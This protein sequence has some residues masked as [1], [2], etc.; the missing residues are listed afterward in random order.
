LPRNISIYFPLIKGFANNVA[1]TILIYWLSKVDVAVAPSIFAKQ[2]YN[3]L[4]VKTKIHIISNGV[5]LSIFS[6]N[7]ENAQIF[8]KRY[9]S[10]VDENASKALFVGRIMPDKDIELFIRA[11]QN[12][13]VVP[14]LVGSSWPKYIHKLKEIDQGKSVFTGQIPLSHLRGAY[15]ACDMFV[16][17]CTTELQSLSVLEALASELPV[18][19]ADSGSLPEL[20]TNQINGFLFSL[21][22]PNDLKEKINKLIL[23][24]ELGKKM[25]VMGR[26]I[27]KK[28]SLDRIAQQYI[29]L[30][31]EYLK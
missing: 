25:G 20:V 3:T 30:Y 7:V 16:Q 12:I 31:S 13:D 8:S 11:S 2:Y 15:S 28:H 6:R 9:L 1:K 19:A 5:D 24:K 21:S 4:G 26:E 29:T 14:I 23:Q 27:A 17:P 18:I 22:S 10:E